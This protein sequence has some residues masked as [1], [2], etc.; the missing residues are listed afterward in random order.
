[1]NPRRGCLGLYV[2]LAAALA[3]SP[4]LPAW[5]QPAAD[6]RVSSDSPRGWT[7]TPEQQGQA[8]EAALSFLTALDQGDGAR[9]YATLSEINRQQ[10]SLE[11]FESTLRKFNADAGAVVERRITTI[12]WNKDPPNA[13]KPGVY[14][15]LDLV[16]RFAQVDRH[17]GYL[18][19]YQTDAGQP[20]TVMR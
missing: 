12:T 6:V 19:L 10:Q 16:S 5:A 13:P 11:T 18:V 8:R 7:P 2:V 17:C 20:F 15:A 4:Q 9:A 1:M 14:V 3:M